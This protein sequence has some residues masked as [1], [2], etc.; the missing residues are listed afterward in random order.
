MESQIEPVAAEETIRSLW[1][2][3]NYVLLW[4]GQAVSDVGTQVARL[5]FPLLILSFTGSPA[6]AGLAQGIATV[7]YLMLSLVAGALVDRWN[8][9]RVMILCDS[10]RALA[11]VS[12]PLA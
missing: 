2:N 8:R 11:A 12:I 9:R 6:Q 5:A 3:R 4:S 10:G 1:S 7:P